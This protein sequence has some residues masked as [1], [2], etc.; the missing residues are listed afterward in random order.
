MA[1]RTGCGIIVT[2]SDMSGSFSPATCGRQPEKCQTVPAR[3]GH[4]SGNSA[5]RA[6]LL[7][8]VGEAIGENRHGNSFAAIFAFQYCARSRD[9]A[10]KPG[11]SSTADRSITPDY[12]IGGRHDSDI[13]LIHDLVGAPKR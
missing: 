4:L 13:R 5:Q 11:T 12:K 1:Q 10:I 3:T 9:A 2:G 7:A 8:L 6:V